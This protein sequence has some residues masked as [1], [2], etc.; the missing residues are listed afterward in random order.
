MSTRNRPLTVIVI[1]GLLPIAAASGAGETWSTVVNN[2]DVM[3]NSTKLF[4]SYNQPSIDSSGFVVFRARSKG[5]GEPVRGIYARDMSFVGA[6]LAAVAAVGDE[7]PQPNNTPAGGSGSGGGLAELLEFP[8]FPR[9]DVAS[10]M[11]ATRA[12]TQPTWTFLLEDG[13]E[14]RAGTASVY[15]TVEGQFR[16]GACLLGSVRDAGNGALVFPWW[17]VPGA[18]EDTRFDQFPGA[19]SPSDNEFVVFKGNWTD[20]IAAT[21][22]TGVYFRSMRAMG[23]MAPVQRIADSQMAIPGQTGPMLVPFGSTAPPSAAFGRMVFLGLD[24]EDA[25]T[26]GGIYLAELLPDPPLDTLVEIGDQVPGEPKG[27]SFTRIGEAL[28]FDGRWVGFWAAWGSETRSVVLTCPLDGNGAIIEFCNEQYPKGFAVEVPV[29]QGFFVVDTRTGELHS[30]A[31]TGSVIDDMMYWNFSGS[32]PG[33]GGGKGGDEGGEQEPPRWRSASFIAVSGTGPNTFQAVFKARSEGQDRLFRASGPGGE[34]D[35]LVGTGSSGVEIDAEAPAASAVVSV[36]IERDGLRNGV[37]AMTA[38]M[39]DEATGESWAGVYVVPLS[40]NP[41]CVADLDG[42]GFVNAADL[43]L[44][45][46][47]WGC[48]ANCVGDLDGDGA[49]GASDLKVLLNVW[50]ACDHGGV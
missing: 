30:V 18:P 14:S 24:N 12:Q 6:P 33:S 7:A 21:G 23:G 48:V 40:A 35:A 32:P 41:R 19:A 17:R 49:V 42:D 3:P 45:L 28:S 16:T 8:S 25:P 43:G 36:G 47:R 4:N 10:R 39:L 2:G 44:L 1:A 15:A 5:P 50:G 22:R 9:I 26:M 29:E 31:K 13:S 11:I 38:S 20:A 46:A 27:T 34:P 37:L